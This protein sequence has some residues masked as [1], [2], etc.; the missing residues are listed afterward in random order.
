MIY[1]ISL[2]FKSNNNDVYF[3]SKYNDL[4]DFSFFNRKYIKEFMIFSCRECV[5]AMD[6]D[7]YVVYTHQVK[8]I[9]Y[10]V[11]GFT[12]DQK[13]YC[14]MITNKEYPERMCWKVGVN[15]VTNFYK[16]YPK[17]EVERDVDVPFPYLK[18]VFDNFSQPD[19][20]YKLQQ[21]LKE[22]KHIMI[23]NIEKV[24]ERQEKLDYMVEKSNDLSLASKEFYK[25]SKKLN[26]CC[27]IL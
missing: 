5:K 9:K 18:V 11:Y 16:E 12:N 4:S 24:L 13:L 21:D 6:N 14:I 3:L 19:K 15:C 8:D 17:Y 1:I 2:L 10:S 26:S 7:E 22:V 20:I 25:Q 23:Q 27:I